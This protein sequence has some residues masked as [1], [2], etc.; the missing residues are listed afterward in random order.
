MDRLEC[1][2]L[3]IKEGDP[4]NAKP[5]LV[6]D[7]SLTGTSMLTWQPIESNSMVGLSF[8]LKEGGF[9]VKAQ[10]AWSQKQGSVWHT[11]FAFTNPISKEALDQLLKVGKNEETS[12]TS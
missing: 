1:S 5:C 3:A 7:I 2:I 6:T 4:P 9:T 11:G 12:G 10:E 8:K